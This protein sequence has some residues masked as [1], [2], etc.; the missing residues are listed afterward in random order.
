MI[1]Q[2]GNTG[3]VSALIL[4]DNRTNGKFEA[5]ETAINDYEQRMIAYA[6]DAQPESGKNEIEMHQPG[7]SFQKRFSN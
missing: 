7:F 3:P 6:T 4:S 2:G 5:I 1:G